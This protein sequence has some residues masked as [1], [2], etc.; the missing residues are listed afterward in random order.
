MFNFSSY[1]PYPKPSVIPCG[2][3]HCHHHA[4]S[5]QVGD[6][7]SF[8]NIFKIVVILDESGSMAGDKARM[9][10]SL[11]GL[12]SEQKQVKGRPATFTL[13]KF[14]NKINRKIV[15][16]LIENVRPLTSEDY[17][18]DGSTALYDA[19]GDTINWFR[20]EHDVLMVIVTDGEENASRSYDREKVFRMIDEKKNHNNWSYVYLS[21]DLQTLKQ[22][23]SLGMNLDR[24]TTCQYMDKEKL[25]KYVS[26][27]V[28]NAIKNYRENGLS[29]QSQLNTN[30]FNVV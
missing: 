8:P 11:N 18:P 24:Q 22:G 27:D 3:K 5:Q 30:G 13:V 17:V 29:V 16:T 26:Y 12:I 4:H 14:N 10:E 19:I 28:S 25:A 2:T 9:L 7:V 15:N 23:R 20:N 21:N 1:A 6:T